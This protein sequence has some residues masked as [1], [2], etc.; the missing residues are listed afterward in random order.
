MAKPSNKKV[1]RAARTTGGRTARG[2]RPWGFY[3]ALGIV[4]A[5]GSFV[6]YTSREDRLERFGNRADTPPTKADHWHA[7]LGI[8]ECDKFL[9]PLADNGRDPHGIHT[10]GDGIIHI[11][12]F[13]S[14]AS[15]NNAVLGEYAETMNMKLSA[16]RFSVPGGK[17]W[18]DG[19]ECGDKS[20]E[21]Q[22]FVN[23]QRRS[24]DPSS[25]KM[26]DRDMIVL[27]FAPRDAEIPKTPPSAPNLDNLTDMGPTTTVPGQPPGAPGAPGEP[28]TTPTTA[29]GAAPTEPTPTT[30]PAT[31]DTTAAPA[32]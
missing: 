2:A 30:A 14:Q 11:H 18:D 28:G 20:G 3:T 16:T 25:Y 8:Y 24:G 17:T 10:H 21:V 1:S 22:L 7:A 9:P 23:G 29:P 15:G 13:D 5:L 26:N 6:L 4:I 32:P 19:D 12:P 31:T 27:A